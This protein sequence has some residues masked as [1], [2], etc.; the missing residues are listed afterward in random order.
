MAKPLEVAEKEFVSWVRK[1]FRLEH[2]NEKSLDTGRDSLCKFDVCK[3]PDCQDPTKECK[4]S[5]RHDIKNG[6]NNLSRHVLS[7]HRNEEGIKREIVLHNLKLAKLSLP[8][9]F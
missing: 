9:V 8:I 1:Y 7:K 5:Y 6:T 2:R 3:L 4:V